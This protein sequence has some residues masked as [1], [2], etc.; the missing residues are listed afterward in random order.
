MA[1]VPGL[2]PGALIQPKHELYGR[3]T[4]AYQP[5]A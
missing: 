2:P 3:M 4:H 5:V 1:G